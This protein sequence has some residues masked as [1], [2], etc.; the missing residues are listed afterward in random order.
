MYD[1]EK[2]V[3]VV[4]AML[5]P[6]RFRIGTKQNDELRVCFKP[7]EI[8]G[9]GIRNRAKRIHGPTEGA[10]MCCFLGNPFRREKD[11]L[12]INKCTSPC[13]S[14]SS[15]MLNLGGDPVRLHSAFSHINPMAWKVPPWIFNECC[16]RRSCVLWIISSAALRVN[17]MRRI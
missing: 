8:A 6:F 13:A 14:S 3:V 4:H 11:S 5:A 7:R 17:V 12:L 10:R 16:W 9:D 15:M 2:Q 1:Q